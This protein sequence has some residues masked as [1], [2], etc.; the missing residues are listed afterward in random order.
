[1]TNI[2]YQTILEHVVILSLGLTSL[3]NIFHSFRDG[4]FDFFELEFYG[5][6]KDYSVL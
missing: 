1:M 4:L 6:S 5:I 3:S 2:S